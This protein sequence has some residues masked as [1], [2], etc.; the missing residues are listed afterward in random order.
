M[1]ASPYNQWNIFW[2]EISLA[3]FHRT[4]WGRLDQLNG[5][6]RI[7]GHFK[8]EHDDTPEKKRGYPILRQSHIYTVYIHNT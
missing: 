7:F 2:M 1:E 5:G 6:Y 4:K 8:K 3:F